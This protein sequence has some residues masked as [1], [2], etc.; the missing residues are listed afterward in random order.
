MPLRRAL[1]AAIAVL[2]LTPLVALAHPL[3][4]FTINHYA[5]IRIEPGRILLDIV[6]DQAEIPAF[7]ARQEFDADGDGEVSDAEA[8]VAR[9]AACADQASTLRLTVAG[10]PAEL[11]LT[12]AGLAFPPGAGGLSTMRL[13][14][15]FEA[16]APAT[17]GPDTPVSFADDSF[18]DRLGWREI[19]IEGSG[20]VVAPVEGE[21][22]PTSVSKRLTEYPEDLLTRALAD[23]SIVVSASAGGPELPPF[24]V[25]DA[26]ALG[27]AP[28]SSPGVTMAPGASSGGA[29]EAPTASAGSAVPS[30]A[31]SAGMSGD[32]VPG[33]VGGEIPSIFG[34]ADLTPVVLVLSL[35][36]AAALGA[37]HALTPGHGKTLMAA[38]LVGSRG[39]PVHA[40]GLGLSVSGSHTL[41]ILALAALVVGAQGIL[42]PDAVVRIA[43][44]V[45]AISIVAIGAWMLATELRRRRRANDGRAHQE[46]HRHEHPHA[47]PHPHA[48][49]TDEG[50][51]GHARESA[52]DDRGG[53]AGLHSHGG[54]Q[55]SH[56][57]PPGAAITWKSLFVLGLAG[58][59]IPST[60]ALLILL[61]SI[62]AGRAPFGVVL[63][64][65][66]GLGMALVMAGVGL[67]MIF[68]RG[69]FESMTEGTALG[70][71]REWVPLGAAVVVLTLGLY[72]TTQAVAGTPVL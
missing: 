28:A 9:P 59:I 48:H 45:A 38:Y 64:V 51:D 29:T 30:G 3:G 67:A 44:V 5:G 10:S 68:A 52:V 11:T 61:G 4:N 66:F 70:R 43:P 25:D 57:P 41:G 36:T 54:S 27:S 62:A 60:S 58:G 42:P 15:I 34:T 35:L 33:G 16:A 12:S 65:A 22:R 63:V 71:I 13:V 20:V 39:S 32:T 17:L 18:A 69:R 31:P 40:L 26:T 14:C 21:V 23:R 8:D 72:L 37:G 49:G 56:V 50:P 53:D 24:E 47:D 46:V 7:Q 2:L 1:L 19:V 6:I 55:H